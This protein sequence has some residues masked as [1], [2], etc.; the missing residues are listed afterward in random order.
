M[1]DQSLWKKELSF[2]RKPKDQADADESPATDK[3]P[4]S[5]WKKELS[6]K[7][8]PK[9]D[10]V[11][12]GVAADPP[13]V[14]EPV[15]EEPDVTEEPVWKRAVSF[16]PKTSSHD[17][18]VDAGPVVVEATAP[19]EDLSTWNG[20]RPCLL[21]RNGH[22][23]RRL[24]AGFLPL[25]EAQRGVISEERQVAPLSLEEGRSSVLRPVRARAASTTRR[26]RT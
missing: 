11:E 7:R 24:R 13:V 4:T 22:G 3:K 5:M 17:Q 14:E 19:S 21:A 25:G 20:G 18:P 26:T 2:G 16:S 12:D 23:P 1:D 10:A 15:A 8:K 9:A 6:F